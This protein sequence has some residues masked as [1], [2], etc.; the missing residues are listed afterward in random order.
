MDPEVAPSMSSSGV[1]RSLET[2]EIGLVGHDPGRITI[3][4]AVEVVTGRSSVL[5]FYRNPPFNRRLV[6]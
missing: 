4:E 2:W 5:P 6:L 3:L 1:R